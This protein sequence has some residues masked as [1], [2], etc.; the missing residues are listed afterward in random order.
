MW[1]SLRIAFSSLAL[2]SSSLEASLALR[3]ASRS[4]LTPLWLSLRIAFSSLAL[5]SS[6]L[7]ASL[8]LRAASRSRRVPLRLISKILFSF[9][10]VSFSAAKSLFWFSKISFSA[11]SFSLSFLCTAERVSSPFN[12]AFNT[13]T[14]SV[15]SLFSVSNSLFWFSKIS[16]SDFRFSF[17]FLYTVLRVSSPL[18]AAFNTSTLSVKASL[19]DF[20]SP[21]SS[22]NLLF[23]LVNWWF[24]TSNSLFNLNISSEFRVVERV[25]ALAL[26]SL[27]LTTNPAP[28]TLKA[29]ATEAVPF[30][31]FLS[32]YC[33]FVLFLAIFFSLF[34][35]CSV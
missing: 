18:N 29:T 9:A 2:A 16:F 7:E 33:L 15:N 17:S 32:E 31:S 23:S 30:F 1:L 35:I 21:F 19:S 14:L 6:S 20:N 27:L 8:A 25:T 5:A 3:D 34:F 10:R 28:K 11:F 22:V 13:S 24:L 26:T 4:R 12:A